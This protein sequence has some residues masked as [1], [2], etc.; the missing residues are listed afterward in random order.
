MQ[1]R[2]SR[3]VTAGDLLRKNAY[4]PGLH[5]AGRASTYCRIVTDLERFVS[6]SEGC[7]Q[8]VCGRSQADS[9]S[10]RPARR[11]EV[12]VEYGVSEYTLVFGVSELEKMAARVDSGWF[13]VQLTAMRAG[14]APPAW[15]GAASASPVRRV[16]RRSSSYLSAPHWV[17]T[18]HR[19]KRFSSPAVSWMMPFDCSRVC[20]SGNPHSV[21]TTRKR[22]QSLI[23]AAEVQHI[24]DGMTA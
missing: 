6:R 18:N 17:S 4:A 8:W 5:R 14:D 3:V 12:L 19:M 13:R 2:L 1:R 16:W 7:K 9:S 10:V 22:I 23:M 21:E 15:L 11:S 20:C 24:V